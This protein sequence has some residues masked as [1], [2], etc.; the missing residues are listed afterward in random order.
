MQIGM[1]KMFRDDLERCED[2]EEFREIMTKHEPNMVL[3]SDIYETQRK[4][5][6]TTVLKMAEYC[7]VT[8]NTARQWKQKIPVKREHV[9]GIGM[10]WDMNLQQINRLLTR[11]GKYPALYSKNPQDAIYIYLINN[12]KDFKDYDVYEDKYKT[13]FVRDQKE[14][15]RKDLQEPQTC[16]LDERLA[17]V[18]T[19]QEFQ[20]FMEEN[21]EVFQRRNHEFYDFVSKYMEKQGLN[22]NNLA[23][24]KKIKNIY[25]NAFSNFKKNGLIPKRSLLLALGI[26]LSMQVEDMNYMLELAGMEAL[27][28]KDRLEAA[29][30]FAMEDLYLNNPVVV[31][32]GM[33]HLTEEQ[34]AQIMESCGGMVWNERTSELQDLETLI[35]EHKKRPMPEIVKY[36]DNGELVQVTDYVKR[37]VQELD[38][39]LPDQEL[40]LF[41]KLL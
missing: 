20:K 40:D 30:I 38:A 22:A 6:N 8:R 39:D 35:L 19:D 7:Q 9:I 18:Q 28:P 34:E 25:N 31:S 11:Y 12:R 2:A 32:E 21:V 5:K 33:V 15:E 10:Y 17:R 23:E 29:V 37:R 3:W 27:C 1:T 14:A 13:F 16:L 36:F 4:E 26:H 24:D 41:L